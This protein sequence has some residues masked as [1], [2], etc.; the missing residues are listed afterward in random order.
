MAQAKCVNNA[1]CALITGASLKLST[2]PIHAAHERFIVSLAGQRP[3]PI[4]VDPDAADLHDRADH[5][6]KVFNAVSAYV[7]VI[8]DD[9]A[10]NTLG[11]LNLV[12]I[13]A[14]LSDL[15]SEV[16]DTIRHAADA[17]AG[18]FA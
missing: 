2:S 4:L 14:V 8:L 13:E 1:I 9:T 3:R 18:R 5:L 17:T 7:A 15:S 12:H 16:T 11:G 6:D 10:Q